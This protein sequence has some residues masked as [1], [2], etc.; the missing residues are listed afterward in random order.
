MGQQGMPMQPPVQQPVGNPLAK[1]L[2]QPKIYIRLPSGGNYWPQGSLEKTENGEF[3]VYAMT[4]KD[5]I[6]FKTPDALLNGQATV[7]VIQSCM[8]NI[9]NAWHTPSI[10]MD[11]ILVAIRRASFGDEMT[12]TAK[13]PGTDIMKDFNV[14]LSGITAGQGIQ[15]DGTKLVPANATT[16]ILFF[17]FVF[18]GE[19]TNGNI[20][21]VL[22]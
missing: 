2:R 9:K 11:A 18:A 20:F 5:E 17:L 14:N 22:E 7:D 13:V 10:D 16:K 15:W 8:P 19:F 6:T 21:L 12:M 1:H 3:P 4:A